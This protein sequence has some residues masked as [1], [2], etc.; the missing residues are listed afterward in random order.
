[1]KNKFDKQKLYELLCEIPRGKVV[2]YGKLAEMLGDK[3]WARA[4]G[5]ALHSNPDGD[6][7]PCYKVVNGKGELSLSYAFGGIKEQKR[8][9]EADGIKVENGKVDLKIYGL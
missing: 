1:M 9:L 6:K 2:T 7:Y 4:V 3:S 8:R 5:N